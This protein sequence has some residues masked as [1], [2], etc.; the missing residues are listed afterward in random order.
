MLGD[1]MVDVKYPTWPAI[2]RPVECGS[3]TRSPICRQQNAKVVE[4]R[5]YLPTGLGSSIGHVPSWTVAVAQA[6]DRVEQQGW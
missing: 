6:A 3:G 5:R 1:A 4:L 2:S